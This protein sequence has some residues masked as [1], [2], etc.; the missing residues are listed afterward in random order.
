MYSI[1]AE[2]HVDTMKTRI[3]GHSLNFAR[4][5]RRSA[6]RPLGS[7]YRSYS[8]GGGASRSSAEPLTLARYSHGR[9]RSMLHWK[10][11]SRMESPRMRS[12]KNTAKRAL[13]CTRLVRA[14]DVSNSR[15]HV[16]P[17]WTLGVVWGLPS[18]ILRTQMVACMYECKKYATTILKVYTN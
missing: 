10:M 11:T 16:R 6:Q 4:G 7:V 18:Q 13:M 2:N 17:V 3:L 8:H 14:A 9:G 12:M 15:S 1:T 5:A